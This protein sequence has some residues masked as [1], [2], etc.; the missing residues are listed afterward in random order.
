MYRGL[1][2]EKKVLSLQAEPAQEHDKIVD[3]ETA[4]ELQG[5]QL[6]PALEQGDRPSTATEDHKLTMLEAALANAREELAQAREEIAQARE[7]IKNLKTAFEL[8]L[9]KKDKIIMEQK[10]MINDLLQ[11]YEGS[12]FGAA[13]AYKNDTEL[14]DF[15]KKVLKD[16][17]N[18]TALCE[19]YTRDQELKMETLRSLIDL[20]DI[21][22]G[23]ANARVEYAETS[24]RISYEKGRISHEH[25]IKTEEKYRSEAKLL[26][27]VREM[28]ASLVEE[29][30][31]SIAKF[32]EVT[33][34]AR[35]K[36]GL[37]WTKMGLTAQKVDRTSSASRDA[38]SADI[39][40]VSNS[41]GGDMQQE[42]AKAADACGLPRTTSH[43]PP[44]PK[45]RT[46]LKSP[47]ER[48]MLR[49]RNRQTL[50]YLNP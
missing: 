11:A 7:E 19:T 2:A 15:L 33:A 31:A 46:P 36:Y 16:F 6:R 1:R 9:Q 37:L 29:D 38:D 48:E 25:R 5:R 50:H 41:E 30:E 21:A 47:A 40:Q 35:R 24:L 4:S 18:F 10:I 42:K 44:T 12:S 13:S 32:R 28:L 22:I 39:S 8:Q 17:H 20:Q 14:P 3:L 27:S 45:P 43:T 34:S 23:Q 49:L 26:V